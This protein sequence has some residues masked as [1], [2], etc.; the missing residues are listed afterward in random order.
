MQAMRFSSGSMVVRAAAVL[1]A[2]CKRMDPSCKRVPFSHTRK[3]LTIP[4]CFL[5]GNMVP[6]L[7]S[8]TT[9]TGTTSPTPSGS[10]NL[11]ALVSVQRVALL[12]QPVRSKSQNNLLGSG[13]TSSRPSAFNTRRSMSPARVMLAST[14]LVSTLKM[15]RRR[16]SLILSHRHCGQLH[17]EE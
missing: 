2:C 5:D 14:S 6:T 1:R 12:V 9:T 4:S 11:Q 10:N 16:A 13:R 17:P 7:R 15:Q 3:P 8:R